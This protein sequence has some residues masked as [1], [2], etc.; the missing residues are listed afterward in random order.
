MIRTVGHRGA[1]SLAPENTLKGFRIAAEL[2]V[3]WTECDVQLTADGHMVVMHDETV[4]R[5]TDGSGRV[6]ELTFEQVRALDAGGGERVPTLQE[7]LA[8]VRGRLRLQIE[9]KGPGTEEP[10]IAAV[11]GMGMQEEV[12]FIS[13]D[14]ER[15]RRVKAIDPH[16]AVG[17]VFGEPPADACRRAVEARARGIYV[18]HPHVGR[19]LVAEAHRHGLEIGAWNPDTEDEWRRLIELGVDVL[20]TNR[21]DALLAFL[22]RS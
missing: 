20:S 3:D 16:L 12:M 4:E 10:G 8:E 18:A 22:G 14:L 7:V 13:F 11:V 19:S 2:G 9:L 17:A 21:P 15:L 5:T 6:A 1:P